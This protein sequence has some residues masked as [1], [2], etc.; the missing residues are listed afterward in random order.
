[1]SLKEGVPKG[2]DLIEKIEMSRALTQQKLEALKASKLQKLEEQEILQNTQH[3]Q[4]LLPPPE[5]KQQQA[6]CS[7]V[8]PPLV[9]EPSAVQRFDQ[10][11]SEKCGLIPEDLC[12]EP[13][14]QPPPKRGMPYIDG[15]GVRLNLDHNSTS[16][17]LVVQSV[18]AAA[19]KSVAGYGIYSTD[20]RAMKKQPEPSE[21]DTV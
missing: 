3:Q 5:E 11:V 20:K 19:A 9:I 21:A 4:Q 10:I 2:V 13:A 8:P 1:M 18:N 6:S 16:K 12:F 17:I 15:V 7:S 14:E